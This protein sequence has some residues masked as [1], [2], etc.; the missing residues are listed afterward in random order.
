MTA[1]TGSLNFSQ[2][3]ESRRWCQ[4]ARGGVEEARVFAGDQSCH[5]E[6]IRRT[7]ARVDALQS[8]INSATRPCH[9]LRAGTCRHTAP[10]W[11]ARLGNEVVVMKNNYE[12]TSQ[13][14]FPYWSRHNR[15]FA[16]PTVGWLTPARPQDLNTFQAL[17]DE[18]K[19][20]DQLCNLA[21]SLRTTSAP[22]V[23]SA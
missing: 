19:K 22:A 23:K 11:Y 12:T 20:G 13:A 18:C 5:G 7:S 17:C 2:A 9:Q 16:H 15:L 4:W 6:E 3:V 10:L 1:Q 21:P 8:L 14:R